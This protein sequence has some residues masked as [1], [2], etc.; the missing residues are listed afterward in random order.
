METLVCSICK[1][2]NS[3]DTYSDRQKT[4]KFPKCNKCLTEKGHVTNKET[5]K[6][7]NNFPNMCFGCFETYTS[8]NSFSTYQ[9]SQDKPKCKKCNDR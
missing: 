3:K 7:K 1:E 6:F 2:V 4:K 5:F 9:Y 8:K